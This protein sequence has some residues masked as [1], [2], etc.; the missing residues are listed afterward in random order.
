MYTAYTCV[1]L[2]FFFFLAALGFELRVSGS[3]GRHL[4]LE[5][6]TAP[7]CDGSQELFAQEPASN[8][9]PP[10][11]CHLIRKDYRREPLVPGCLC[12]LINLCVYLV[13]PEKLLLVFLVRKGVQSASNIIYQFFGKMPLYHLYFWKM[14][15]LPAIRFL[16]HVF[17]FEYFE[18]IFPTV[19]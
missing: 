16:V 1:Y 9:E 19:F 12:V 5:H 18:T 15:A 10:Y 6:S 4:S 13:Q 7:F 11:L 8:H 17:F 3:L 2:C 14:I